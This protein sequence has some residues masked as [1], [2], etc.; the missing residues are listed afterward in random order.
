MYVA[1]PT[2]LLTQT[3]TSLPY[4][5]LCLI[6]THAKHRPSR[7]KL[8]WLHLLVRYVNNY[9]GCKAAENKALFT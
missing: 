1:A 7:S 6:H 5:V 9:S 3:G 4:V 2:F 8:S